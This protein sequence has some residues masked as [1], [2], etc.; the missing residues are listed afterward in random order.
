V[1][2]RYSN[3][4]KKSYAIEEKYI[5]GTH[6]KDKEFKMVGFKKRGYKD[7]DPG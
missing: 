3:G 5:E 7:E 6:L 4:V 1:P 2:I